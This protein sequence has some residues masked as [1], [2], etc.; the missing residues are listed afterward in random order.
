MDPKIEETVGRIHSTQYKIVLYTT[1]GAAQAPSWLLSTPGASRTVLE[2]RVPY[3]TASLS[4]VLG[5]TPQSY[6][7]AA[8]AIDMAIAAY[9]QAA[10]LSTIGTPILGVGATC[11][12]ATD[13]DRRGDHKAFVSVHSGTSTRTYS[14]VFSKGS[15]GRR[16]EDFLASKLVVDAIAAATGV[17]PP[18]A[19][20]TASLQEQGLLSPGDSLTESYVAVN[21]KELLRDML[22]GR[23]KCLE[24]NGAGATVVDAPRPGRVY[25]PG[26][27]N[28]L[29]DGHKTLLNA[30]V[31]HVAGSTIHGTTNTGIQ[32]T[33]NTLVNNE[34]LFEL[35]VGNAD[36]GLLPLP[37][38]ERRVQ[39]FVAAGLPVVIT[40][41][42][43]FTMKAELFPA[44]T[45][46]VGYDTAARLVQEGYYGSETSM[47]LQFA[48]L[49][50][51][52]CKFLVAGRKEDSTGRF[53]TLDN[54][55]VPAVLQR[56][57]LF[58]C[59]KQEEFRMDVS[60]TELRS[61]G[62]GVS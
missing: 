43:L 38:L 23:F 25:L 22:N 48:K 33:G 57:H 5:H 54:L 15:R 41:A 42:P 53:L 40:Q 62:Q 37:E 26:S 20:S 51:V 8:T 28:P 3:A 24:F 58:D 31:E 36:K 35:S 39:Q 56:G 11:A 14:L 18:S 45:F 1:G 12:L 50:H 44:S 52:G 4:Q 10:T 19:V 59:L 27:F 32:S 2:A 16:E 13:R 7:S 46:V 60:S 49:A 47:L 55:D 30:A 9:K 61:K 29:H 6:A 21:E 17:V 34:G